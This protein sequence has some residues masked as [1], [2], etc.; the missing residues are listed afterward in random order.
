MLDDIVAWIEGKCGTLG[1]KVGGR[2]TYISYL[3]SPD[4]KVQPQNK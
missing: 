2:E 1:G 4:D 3:K